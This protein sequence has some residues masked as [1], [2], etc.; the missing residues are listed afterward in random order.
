M[1]AIE[2]NSLMT[3]KINRIIK[4]S[5][6]FFLK[7]DVSANKASHGWL[8]IT[9]LRR[10]IQSRR[11]SSLTEVVVSSPIF[12]KAALQSFSSSKRAN[13]AKTRSAIATTLGTRCS[14]TSSQTLCQGKQHIYLLY[15]G[16]VPYRNS[17]YIHVHCLPHICIISV[18]WPTPS[19]CQPKFLQSQWLEVADRKNLSPYLQMPWMHF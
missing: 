10:F 16:M 13:S 17:I 11:C 3:I 12:G 19:C 6:S 14:S 1:A 7:K 4:G 2:L 9:Q 18:P 15:L 8:S 5:F